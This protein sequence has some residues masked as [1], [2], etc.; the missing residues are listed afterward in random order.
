MPSGANAHAGWLQPP[1]VHALEIHQH[2]E[3]N[4]GPADLPHHEVVARCDSCSS[5]HDATTRCRPS[6]GRK[7]PWPRWSG[8][9]SSRSLDFAAP[10]VRSRST[11]FTRS[12]E[13]P[14]AMLEVVELIE[15]GA[16]GREQHGVSRTRARAR[17][18]PTARFEGPA[19]DQRHRAA[20]MRFDLRPPPRR[21]AARARAFA[22]QR[23]AQHRIVAVL[24]LA[25]ED[26]PQP[27]VERRRWP[28][29]S[30]RRWWLSNRCSSRRRAARARIRGDARRPGNVITAAANL[31]ERRAGQ[32]GQRAPRPWCSPHC[33]RRAGECPPLP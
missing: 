33:A 18:T 5:R 31:L 27:A 24:V 17:A 22:A 28:S 7:T 16:G 14:P 30:R 19:L 1:V 23:L 25:A 15:A 3:R 9:A 20:Q 4:H 21:S 6:P 10:S 12:L 11:A 8:T 32:A 26:H 2:E 13:L 29:A